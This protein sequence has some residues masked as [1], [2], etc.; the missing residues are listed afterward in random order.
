[1]KTFGMDLRFGLRMLLRSPAVTLVAL[2]TLAIGIGG[3]T[4]LFSVVDG[5]L[6]RPLAHKDPDRLVVLRDVQPAVPNAPTSYPEYLRWKQESGVFEDLAAMFNSSVS[7]TGSGE[8][9]NLPAMRVS[10]NLLPMLG[11]TP[12]LGRTHTEAE[13][14]RGGERVAVIG[15]GLWRRRFGADAAIVGKPVTL[16]GE[17]WTVIGVVP[18]SFS[19]GRPV[20]VILPLR[21]ST[22]NAPQGLHFLF[23]AG[24]LKS[25]LPMEQARKD[26]GAR[27]PGIAKELDSGHDVRILGLKEWIV[28]DTS[29]TLALLGAALG[30]VL[31]IACANVAGLLLARAAGRRQE[32]AIRRAI[33][34]GR[35]DLVR[36]FL[37]ESVLL[38]IGGGILGTLLAVWGVDLVK[39]LPGTGI[40]R[41]PNV[42]IDATVLLFTLGLSMLTGLLFG[43][44]PALESASASMQQHLKGAV[45]LAGS[46]RRVQRMRGLMV[47]GQVS[48][49]LLLLVGAGLLARSLIGVLRSDRGFDTSNVMS[50][51]VDL[52]GRQGAGDPA[53]RARFFSDLLDRIRILPG[54]EAA[55][56]CGHLPLSGSNTN[57]DVLIEG[58]PAA[59][60][61]TLL[62]ELRRVSEDYFTVLHI[63]VLRGRAFTERDALGAPAVAIVNQAFVDRFLPGQEVV[64]RRVDAQWET[65]GWQEIVGVVGNIK[66]DALD[67]PPLPELYVPFRQVPM[68]GMF[69]VVRS[70][71]DPTA[72]SGALR[73]AVYAV[74]PDQPVGRMR[75]MD[76]LLSA[77]VGPRRLTATMVGAF[78]WMALFLASIGI[79]G[80]LA[81]WVSERRR[82]IGLRMALGARPRQV[83]GL[84]VSR[85]LTLTGIGLLVGLA[86]SAG[87]TRLLAGF[88]Y[89]I[90][91]ADPPTLL[92]TP[93][94]L[95][96]VAFLASWLPARRAMRIDPATAL[97]S[98]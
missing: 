46:T 7:L 30:F 33:G 21:L 2:A 29:R 19:F 54:V 3:N 20:D 91:P 92:G 10:A 73:Q 52:P 77:S 57:G 64:G 5:V 18:R 11:A 83:L 97:R 12:M 63:P 42:R 94:L 60:G 13:D 81:F 74:R 93:L 62:S 36:Q 58:R 44:A 25:G 49:S 82:E 86:A 24:R 15:E 37:T 43:L 23:L 28:G 26:A 87:M 17:P 41:L 27:A 48:L 56:T 45:G 89:G 1:M 72:L 59:D 84:V 96:G 68:D 95:G 38:A 51:E 76:D 53:A 32:V 35:A 79:Y 31:L 98:D 88:L 78:A 65:N 16:S 61:E 14:E 50:M 80:L 55:A 75:T 66:H 70:A 34:A 22:E 8:P 39:S 40:P 90:G 71:G 85:G 47:V 67:A 4:V 6:L 9:E 69:A